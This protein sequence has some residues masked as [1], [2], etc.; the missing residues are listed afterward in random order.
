MLMMLRCRVAGSSRK[1]QS[2][3]P[4]SDHMILRLKTE[5]HDAHDVGPCR[6]ER[7]S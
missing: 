6:A 2:A 3:V 7:T 5:A 1:K 4:T